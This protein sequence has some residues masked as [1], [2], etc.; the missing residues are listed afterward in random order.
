MNKRRLHCKM[1]QAPLTV[2][3]ELDDEV[4]PFKYGPQDDSLKIPVGDAWIIER[5]PIRQTLSREKEIWFSPKSLTDQVVTDQNTFGCC[6]HSGR[7]N[8]RCKCGHIIGSRIDECAH[9]PRFEPNSKMTYWA[10]SSVSETDSEIA[11]SR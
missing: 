7:N 8:T 5:L 11:R 4:R 2:P 3:L 10:T 6:G 9:Q 1:C